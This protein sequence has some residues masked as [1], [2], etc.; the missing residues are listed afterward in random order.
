ML[1]N[2][3]SSYTD[4]LGI[5]DPKPPGTLRTFPSLR[6]DCFTFYPLKSQH[7]LGERGPGIYPST[8]P[9]L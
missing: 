3:Q 7:S 2:L 1:T 6:K 8:F 9:T 4:C 5:C